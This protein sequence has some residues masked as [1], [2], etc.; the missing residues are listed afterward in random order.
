MALAPGWVGKWEQLERHAEVIR[1]QGRLVSIMENKKPLDLNLFK[2]K[3]ATF[4]W[5]S[6]F[7]GSMYQTPD[8]EAQ[9]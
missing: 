2:S 1:E 9:G 8:M 6:M 3:S 4:V 7:T 5:E